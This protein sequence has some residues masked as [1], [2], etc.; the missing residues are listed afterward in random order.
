MV[1]VSVHWRATTSA[2]GTSRSSHHDGVSSSD[3]AGV[4]Q[5]GRSGYVTNRPDR[6]A[7]SMLL[8]ASRGSRYR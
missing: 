1:I 3:Q 8:I 2:N 5:P 7:S 6:Q 4:P